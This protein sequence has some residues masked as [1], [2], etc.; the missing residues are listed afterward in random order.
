VHE[1]KFTIT[2]S[3]AVIFRYRVNTLSFSLVGTLRMRHYNTA[4]QQQYTVV[5]LYVCV[6]LYLLSNFVIIEFLTDKIRQYYWTMIIIYTLPSITILVHSLAVSSIPRIKWLSPRQ[7]KRIIDVN[8][9]L[10]IVSYG[11]KVFF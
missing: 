10:I 3:T 1:A 7:C 6:S 11:P 4:L 8:D 9:R 5:Y 2:S